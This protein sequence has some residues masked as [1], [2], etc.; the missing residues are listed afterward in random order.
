VT[1]PK[2]SSASASTTP[3]THANQ[4]S[5]SKASEFFFNKFNNAL[6][7]HGGHGEGIVD[8]RREIRHESELV[9]VIGKK[10]RNV[11][12]SRGA[13]LRGSATATGTTSPRA[14]C[15]RARASGWIGKTCDGFGLLGPTCHADQVDLNNLKIEGTVNGE[16]R[17]SSNTSDMV[18]NCAPDRKLPSTLMTLCARDVIYTGTP[19][20][21]ISGYLQGEAVWLKAGRPADDDDREAG[22]VAV[23]P[24]PDVFTRYRQKEEPSMKKL[25]IATA[26]AAAALGTGIGLLNA[27]QPGFTATVLQDQDLS[28]QGRHA[29]VARA[30]FIPAGRPDVTRHP[31]EELGTSW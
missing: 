1:N 31:G 9:I 12:R 24:R 25:T 28:A 30:E 20:G 11:S 8:P 13:L 3:G 4:Q 6:N 19:E 10:A 27:Q 14:T 21:V 7:S 22:H 5:D 26:L 2:K 17:Q 16:V 18:F 15:S 29:V 23:F